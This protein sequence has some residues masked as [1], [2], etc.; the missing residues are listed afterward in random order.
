[1]RAGWGLAAALVLAAGLRFGSLDAQSYYNDELVTVWLLE[2]P[3]G[4]ML[5]TLPDSESTPPLYYVVAWIWAKAAGTGEAGLRALSA[6]L[7][8]ATVAIAYGA[9][10]ALVSRRVGLVAA[11]IAAVNP[12]LVWYSHEARAYA[13][14]IPL[15]ALSLLLFARARANPS[16]RSLLAWATASAL[17]IASHYFAALV[18]APEA[19]W[20]LLSVRRHRRAVAVAVA[21]PALATLALVPLAWA[22]RLNPGTAEGAPLLRRIAQ[23]PKSF[24]VGF[25]APAELLIAVLASGC[26]LV[27]IVLLVTAA[28]PKARRGAAVAGSIAACV[29]VAP[30]VLATVGPEYVL[31][32][33]VVVALVPALIVIAAG[34]AAS[35]AGLAAA[36][37]YCAVC[38]TVVVSVALDERY[39][40]LD[41]RGAAGTLSIDDRRAVVLTP[42]LSCGTSECEA[43]AWATYFPG[44]R[45]MDERGAEVSEIAS[46]GT[47]S[48]NSFALGPP[49]PP[50]PMPAP[51]PP[52]GFQLAERR[53]TSSYTMLRYLSPVPRRVEREALRSLAID[54]IQ[55]FEVLVQPGS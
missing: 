14:A 38:L 48:L 11:L 12:L 30:I 36:A 27:A 52:R 33:F 29:V 23:I 51:A 49:E 13:L 34:F 20:L 24:L 37:V 43:G 55:P 18:V 46:L 45:R 53:Q 41:W 15:A 54:P 19:I 50:R 32:R 6:L 28:T 35:R 40:R 26:A 2:Q 44:A 3:L 42:S 7:G 31:V 16:P 39:Q 8:T 22:Q 25:N 47:A 1:M 21:L 17:A 10:S 4:D 5:A 9:G